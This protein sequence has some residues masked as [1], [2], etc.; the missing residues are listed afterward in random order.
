MMYTE[1]A[2]TSADLLKMCYSVSSKIMAS[3]NQFH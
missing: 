2:K 1:M 3:I